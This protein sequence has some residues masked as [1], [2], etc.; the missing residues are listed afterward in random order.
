MTVADVLLFLIAMALSAPGQ[1]A[2]PSCRP[3][4]GRL[5]EQVRG[6]VVKGQTFIFSPRVGRDV[7]GPTVTAAPTPEEIAAVG[8]FGRAWFFLESY[9][10]TPPRKGERAAFV[11]MEFSA[12]LTW[13]RGQSR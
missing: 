3:E 9:E 1:Q 7:Q 5:A 8:A 13:P 12:C 11:S 4:P 6:E 10:L 2:P